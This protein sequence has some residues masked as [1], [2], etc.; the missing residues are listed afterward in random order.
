MA[1][2]NPDTHPGLEELSLAFT[3]VSVACS[4]LLAS[5]FFPPYPS[6]YCLP[7]T[8]QPGPHLCL[9]LAPHPSR[10]S[11]LFSLEGFC[12]CL[13]HRVVQSIVLCVSVFCKDNGT[14]CLE[15]WGFTTEKP[16]SAPRVV[17]GPPR[18]VLT[19]TFWRSGGLAKHNKQMLFHA[20]VGGKLMETPFTPST[21]QTL[22][23]S[24]LQT[25]PLNP[26]TLEIQI[27][28]LSEPASSSMPGFLPRAQLLAMPLLRRNKET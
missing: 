2:P 7:P 3:V 22:F 8:V 15:G 10:P 26:C 4:C 24:G 23:L 5:C 28:W 21:A 14:E 18:W 20:W 13:A 19:P 9:S 17:G 11:W 12:C 25:K 6:G 27:P 1:T 16:G